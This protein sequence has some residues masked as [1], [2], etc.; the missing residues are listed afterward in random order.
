MLCPPQNVCLF[1]IPNERYSCLRHRSF[2][3][4][5]HNATGTMRP[6]DC[7]KIS[8]C[9]CRIVMLCQH[10]MVPPSTTFRPLKTP[11]CSKARQKGSRAQTHTPRPSTKTVTPS[12]CTPI[13]IPTTKAMTPAQHRGKHKAFTRTQDLTSLSTKK[14]TS[15]QCPDE[16]KVCAQTQSSSTKMST[17]VQSTGRRE[18]C[19]H[20]QSTSMKMSPTVQSTGGHDQ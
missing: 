15:A 10:H 17:P 19:T 13:R 6:A 5:T 8:P 16:H 11:L 3:P 12:L 20:T 7:S 18:V 1:I 2:L 9:F 14:C 4:N